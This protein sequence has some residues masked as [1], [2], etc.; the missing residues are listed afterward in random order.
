MESSA[1]DMERSRWNARENGVEPH[2]HDRQ[3]D[4]DV[5]LN[6]S[7]LRLATIDPAKSCRSVCAAF[8]GTH[9]DATSVNCFAKSMQGSKCNMQ[10]A[11]LEDPVGVTH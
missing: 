6:A 7:L 2:Y 10:N 4:C 11:C 3:A 1:V 5:V 8:N 9:V